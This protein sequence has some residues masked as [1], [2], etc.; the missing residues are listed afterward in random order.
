MNREKTAIL[1]FDTSNY[2]SS[3]ALVSREEDVILDER[4][5]LSVKQGEK[6]LRQSH[7]LFQHIENLPLLIERAYKSIDPGWIAGIAASSRPRPQEGS[8][9]PVFRAGMAFGRSLAA[10]WSLPYFEFSH[11]EGHLAAAAFQTPLESCDRYLAFHLSGGTSELLIVDHEQHRIDRIGGSKDISFGQLIDRTGVTMGLSFPAGA[12]MDRLA[13]DY[14]RDERDTGHE[15]NRLTLSP[16]PVTNLS[17]NL[18]GIEAQI[19]RLLPAG[20]FSQEQAAHGLFREI[21]ACL[22]Q[23]TKL[24]AESTGCSKVLYT[25][26]VAASAFLRERI[27]RQFGDKNSGVIAVFGQASLSGDNAV[28]A[29]LLGGKALWQASR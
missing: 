15:G 11:Q 22:I 20:K 24:A 7:A 12:K 3:I 5:P 25:G 17:V 18:S 28:G 29:A 23:W 27:L 13:W 16:I 14:G 9:M 19:S 2:T 10:A 1:S 6:G 4:I 26:G 8:Y 21:A